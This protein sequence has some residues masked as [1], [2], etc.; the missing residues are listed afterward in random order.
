MVETI[1]NHE[2]M[3]NGLETTKHELADLKGN[4]LKNNMW[5][6]KE[7]KKRI[8]N[9]EQF[10][11]LDNEKKFKYLYNKIPTVLSKK[12]PGG[13]FYS[14]LEPGL[15]LK[16]TIRYQLDKKDSKWNTGYGLYL[17]NWKYILKSHKS[18]ASFAREGETE[19]LSGNKL[20]NLLNNWYNLFLHGRK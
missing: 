2:A 13:S 18:K 20:S 8:L 6:K 12:V 15:W 14:L 16:K 19:E 10:K 7:V 5:E 1:R 11:R 9:L 17:D 3:D 4:I